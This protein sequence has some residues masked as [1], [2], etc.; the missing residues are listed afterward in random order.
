MRKLITVRIIRRKPRRKTSNCLADLILELQNKKMKEREGEDKEEEK[1]K[2]FFFCS[3]RRY[4]DIM[5]L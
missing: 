5:V 2:G 4:D 1:E 3:T